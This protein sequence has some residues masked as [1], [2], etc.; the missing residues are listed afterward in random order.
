VVRKIDVVDDATPVARAY[1]VGSLPHVRIYDARGE[2][3]YALTGNA[4]LDAG[5]R[6]VALARE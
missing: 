2:L 4:A 5:S 1:G 3:R 6:A